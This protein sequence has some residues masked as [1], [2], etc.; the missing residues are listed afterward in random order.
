[1][2]DRRR[3][4]TAGI[5]QVTPTI[6][7]IPLSLPDAGLQAVNVYTIQGDDGIGLV[8]G[9]WSRPGALG[10]LQGR[11]AELSIVLDDISTVLTTHFHP[12]HYTLAVE[13]R[14]HTGCPVALGSDDRESVELVM[15]DNRGMESLGAFL[16]R[17]GVP[18]DLLEG[19]LRSQADPAGYEMPSSWLSDGDRPKAGGRELL[20]ISTPGH[21]RGHFCF[22]DDEAGLL[23]AGDHVLPHITPSIGFESVGRHLPLADYLA[24]L[25][26]VRDR[27]DAVLLPAHGPVA[28]SVHARVDELFAH[29]DLRLRRCGDAVAAGARNAYEVAQRIPWTSRDRTFAELAPFDRLMAVHE[30]RAHLAVLE[31]YGRVRLLRSDELDEYTVG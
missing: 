4:A 11:L 26:R 5:E 21:T 13:L 28:P 10:E 20:A 6:H 19:N 23:F 29:H 17:N 14:R 1:M 8:D 12:D 24:S 3:W 9:G 31:T 25:T 15:A 30:A 16:R 22:A 2:A 27:Q 18:T 7:R